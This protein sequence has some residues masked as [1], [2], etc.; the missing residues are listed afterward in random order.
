MSALSDALDTLADLA[1]FAGKLL[2]LASPVGIIVNVG[3]VA[4]R[5]ADGVVKQI[6]AAELERIRVARDTGTA[7][8][9]AAY[10]A[11]RQDFHKVKP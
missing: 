9:Q 6:D 4:L 2:G 11:S 7:A 5:G 10:E 8:G 3:A 1:E